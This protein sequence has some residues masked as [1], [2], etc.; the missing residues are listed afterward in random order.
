MSKR[1]NKNKKDTKKKKMYRTLQIVIVL[2]IILKVFGVF[3]PEKQPTMT[4]TEFLQIVDSEKI[5]DMKNVVIKERSNEITFTYD[6][7]KKDVK[8]PRGEYIY[9]MKLLEKFAKNDINVKIDNGV[10]MTDRFFNVIA[11]L[12]NLAFFGIIILIVYMFSKQAGSFLGDTNMEEV[13]EEK[14]T[15]KDIAGYKYVKEEL[16]EVV[17]FLTKPEDFNKY[18]DKAPKGILL[19][20]PPGNGKTF[21]A[22]ALAGETNTP[23]FQMSAS[24]IEDM[25]VGSGARKLD[26]M[27]KRVKAKAKKDGK[28]ILFIDEIDAVGMKREK[29]TVVE[30]NQTINKLLTELDGFDKESN[31]LIVA[32]TNLASSLDP[33]LTRSGRFDRVI[34][35]DRPNV[36]ER[37]A[38]ISLYL[39]KR[40]DLVAKEVYE[41]KYAAVVAK[42]TE[43]FCNADLDK[44][45]NE[46]ALMARKLKKDHIDIEAIR[47]AYTKIIA[48]I[49]KEQGISDEEKRIVAYHEA[50]HA[51]A[52]ILTNE[53]GVES[54]AYITI[55]PY[56]DS[57]GHVSPVSKDRSLTRKSHLE[58]EIKVLLAGR[59]VEDKILN[60]DYTTGAASDLQKA[61]QMI[62]MYITKLGMSDLAENLFIENI[63]ENN[64]EVQKQAK[65]LRDR[66]YKETKEIIETHY[67]MVEKIAT[68]LLEKEA[69]DQHELATIL[70]GT[71]Y[72]AK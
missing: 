54:V 9:E 6:K 10:T 38:V 34:R 60:G 45:V 1:E 40:G 21:F 30:T 72:Q 53:S 52:Q 2:L 35:V 5:K 19:E 7:K 3:D 37:E 28:A 17:D 62:L 4:T 36:K 59:A 56:G 44:L 55:T 70:E 57:L 24:D 61:N 22:K 14:V 51:V 33:A 65:A 68:T 49:Q 71:S 29:R 15:F 50:G 46:S 23:F 43:G 12:T 16:Q 31:I 67:D 41:E 42:Q 32:A 8:F 20:G 48:G 11:I 27:F 39:E 13:E 66:L 64:T 63:D 58:N 18:T 25:F 69:I 26:S 47:S